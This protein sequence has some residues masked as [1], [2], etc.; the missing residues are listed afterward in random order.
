M[1]YQH[2][3]IIAAP[4]QPP[5]HPAPSLAVVVLRLSRPWPKYNLCSRG[6]QL[7]QSRKPMVIVV[8]AFLFFELRPPGR[9]PP[10][11]PIWNR[12]CSSS[13][14]RRRLSD[15]SLWGGT[16][17]SRR[18]TTEVAGR[19]ETRAAADPL[20]S[21]GT[22]AFGQACSLELEFCNEIPLCRRRQP[23]THLGNQLEV[24]CERP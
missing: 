6:F 3:S 20:F 24:A 9:S 15:M 12:P 7:L 17:T 4:L 14:S 22:P 8:H 10:L 18:S 2:K 19:P 5:R 16:V 21:P 1:P 11:P 13:S 23:D